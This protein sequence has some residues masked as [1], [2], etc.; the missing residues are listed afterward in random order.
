MIP[1]LNQ[2]NI[3]LFIFKYLIILCSLPFHLVKCKGFSIVYEIGVPKMEPFDSK[4]L[5]INSK[6]N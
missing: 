3:T 5:E 6:Y 4:S 1:L 2:E